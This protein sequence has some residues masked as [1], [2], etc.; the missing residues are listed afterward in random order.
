MPATPNLPTP[1]FVFDPDLPGAI[2][3]PDSSTRLC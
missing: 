2:T 3:N 1:D